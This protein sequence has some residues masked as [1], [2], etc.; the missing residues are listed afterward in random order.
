MESIT[1]LGKTYC[2]IVKLTPCVSQR[3]EMEDKSKYMIHALQAKKARVA[4]KRH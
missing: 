2:D 1:Q 3:K 4:M